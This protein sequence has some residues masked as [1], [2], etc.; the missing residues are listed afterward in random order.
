MSLDP[1]YLDFDMSEADY[2]A[3]QRDNP[4]GS[5][6]PHGDVT[7]SLDGDG[8]YDWYFFTPDGETYDA[9][10]GRI[11]AWLAEV[12]DRALIVVAHG[13]VTRV[14]RGL[15]AG[16]PRSAALSLPVP[17][18]VIWRLGDGRIEEIAG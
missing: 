2:L 12:Q 9:F 6:L 15:Y 3:W 13:V 16:L 4:S 1:I 5:G 17:Q 18:G 8:H 10:A 7:I 14:L 11:A